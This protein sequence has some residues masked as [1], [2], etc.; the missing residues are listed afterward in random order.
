MLPR[1]IFA[2]WFGDSGMID[3][4]KVGLESLLN[5]TGV[6]IVFLKDKDIQDWILP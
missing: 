3:I 1:R 2:F 6:E 5:Q 4:R